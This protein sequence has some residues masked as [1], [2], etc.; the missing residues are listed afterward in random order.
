MEITKEDFCIGTW[1]VRPTLNRITRGD[2]EIQIEPRI[3][4]VLICLAHQPG[5]VVSRET[6]LQEAWPGLVVSDDPLNRAISELRKYFEDDPRNPDYIETI[7]KVGYRL[8]APVQS[9]PPL[10]NP[11]FS[12]TRTYTTERTRPLSRKQPE[13]NI[14]FSCLDCSC[15]CPVHSRS[16]LSYRARLD[17]QSVYARHFSARSFYQFARDGV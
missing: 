15:A 1:V 2:E 14:P 7:R 11:S 16:P 12:Q 3:M 9:T 13:Q 10:Q 8:I 17:K 4:R 5:A 6:L